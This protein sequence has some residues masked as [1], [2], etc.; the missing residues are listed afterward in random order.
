MSRLLILGI[1]AGSAGLIEAW[2]DALPT[3]SGF[4]D[5]ADRR[6]RLRGLEHFFIGS[7]WPSLYTG[8]EPG[9]HGHHSLAQLVPGSYRLR[10]MADGPLLNGEP[11]WR[12]LSAAGRDVAILDVPLTELDAGLNGIQ[13]VEW[14]AHDALYGFKA[15]PEPLAAELIGRF[16]AHP[17]GPSCD[18]RRE[19]AADYELLVDRLVRGARLKG[20]LT[21]HLLARQPWDFAI[22]VFTEAHCGGHQCWHQHD[23]SHPAHD[24]AVSAAIGDPLLDVYRAIDT[25]IGEILDEVADDTT[26]GI[27][28]AHD[29]NFWYGLNFMLPEILFALGVTARPVEIRSAAS[30]LSNVADSVWQALPDGLRDRLRPVLHA[31]RPAAPEEAAPPS[32][33]A[34]AANSLCFPLNNGMPVSGIRL[35]LRGREPDGR[36]DPQE[37]DAF[38]DGLAR[39]LTEIV[40]EQTGAQAV[41]RVVRTSDV[42]QGD[43][44]DAL[45]DLLV[46]WNDAVPTGSTALG[47][48][49]S[50]HVRLS[51]PAIGTLTGTN[52]Y[53]RSGEHR[54][55]GFLM[56]RGPQAASAAPGGDTLGILDVA[57]LLERLSLAG[58]A[59]A[60]ATR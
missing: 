31:L 48:G 32:L 49:T 7:T 58:S 51:S 11:F 23:A 26:V 44:L 59:G 33:N 57:P 17:L 39:S 34:D 43:R 25:A 36:L 19:T 21:R 47:D 13:T 35:N 20:E 50:G 12:R 10:W 55:D 3:L 15:H 14:G 60:L 56:L 40:D 30:R 38:C 5:S 24:V 54:P 9:Q 6:Y 18:G 37:A 52:R 53:G 46:H 29:M 16:G 22:Q 4:A 45:P 8:L 28:S 2:S 27:L 42:T 1:D 41:K